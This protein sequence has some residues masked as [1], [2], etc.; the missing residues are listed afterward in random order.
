[1]PTKYRLF[2][3]L[4]FCSVIGVTAGAQGRAIKDIPATSTLFNSGVSSSGSEYA[5]RIQSDQAGP[6]GSYPNSQAVRSVVQTA[7]DWILETAPFKVTPVRSVLV[8]LGDPVSGGNSG[9]PPF[10]SALVNARFIAKCHMVEYGGV[11]MLDIPLGATATCPLAISFEF[12][13]NSFR[14]AMNWANFPDTEPVRIS[15]GRANA[16]QC[17]QWAI[18]P[19][20]LAGDY[21]TSIGKLLKLSAKPREP[22]QDLGNFRFSFSI[23]VSIP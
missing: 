18:T 7:G 10:G 4:L 16:S 20:N 19:M 11:N 3:Q 17:S 13:G 21:P 23:G 14:I 9:A 15:C 6:S 2:A 12:G 5:F 22:D 1:M 8:D